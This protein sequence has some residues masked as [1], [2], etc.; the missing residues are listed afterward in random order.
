MNQDLH[1][2]II[3]GTRGSP[4]EN[5]FPWLA[6]E[7]RKD[8]LQVSVPRFPTPEGQSLENWRR[9]FAEEF[10]SLDSQTVLVGHSIGVAMALRLLE[11]SSSPVKGSFLVSGWHG[12][13]NLPEFD[14]LI[15]S[16]FREPFDYEGIGRKYGYCKM[17]HGSNDPYVPVKMGKELADQ[18]GVPLEVISGGGHLSAESGYTEFPGLLSDIRTCLNSD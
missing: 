15:E 11:A 8:S 12:L 10:N 6:Q 3:H 7:L 16:F 13:L 2:I 17:Y 1:I 14:P 4:E 18:L 9:V 5:W